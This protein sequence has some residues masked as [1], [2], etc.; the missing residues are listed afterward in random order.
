MSTLRNA[1]RQKYK[2]PQDAMKALDLDPS[3]LASDSK[4][5]LKMKLSRKAEIVHGAIV[6]YLAPKLAQDAK[7]DLAPA[8]E[9]VSHKNFAKS[10]AKLVTEVTKL[11]E[12]KLAK[13]AKLADLPG[14][15]M[16][17]DAM[18]TEEEKD[19]AKD[20]SDKEKEKAA[21]DKAARDESMEKLKMIRDS[22]SA[23]DFKAACDEL[24]D[25]MD[26]EDEKDDDE[27][28]DKDKA[29]DKATDK[30]KDKAKD[31]ARD[32][33]EE[34]VDK[35]AMDQALDKAI[36]GERQRARAVRDAE[37]FVRPWVGD[38][39]IA[40]DSASDV[41]KTALEMRGKSVKDIPPSVGA[42]RAILEMM[43]KAGE[44]RQGSSRVAMDAAS[45]K[46]FAEMY[47]DAN[48]IKLTA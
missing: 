7:V 43:P 4:E 37:R 9:G 47:P 14:V 15:L 25:D 17:F 48:K 41:F 16:A 6:A 34:P 40:C 36:E 3:L 18:E 35:K 2:T 5:T 13:D 38:I 31:K 29:K 1:L 46:S 22:M 12:G 24:D 44:Q 26:A 19:K 21:E 32:E 20:E 10:R 28:K 39:A 45:T 42:Y 23:K 30:A 11:V 27:E 8:F 33:K